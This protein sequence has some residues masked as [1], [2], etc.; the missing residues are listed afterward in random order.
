MAPELDTLSLLA[1]YVNSAIPPNA[2]ALLYCICV[3]E[4]PGVPPPE[5]GEL[6]HVVPLLVR[7]G[8]F[9][10]EYEGTTLREH[11]GLGRPGNVFSTTRAV[12]A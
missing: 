12:S 3:V 2:P 8:L 1:A 6:T 4:P 5:G 7:R 11:Y 10:D 9:R